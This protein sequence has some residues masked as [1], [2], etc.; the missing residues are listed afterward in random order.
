MEGGDFG[1]ASPDQRDRLLSAFAR[2]RA[3]TYAGRSR[4]ATCQACQLAIQAGAL[5]YELVADTIPTATAI[6][7]DADCYAIFTELLAPKPR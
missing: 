4:G 5:E 2:A 1:A 3:R 6:L 7:V